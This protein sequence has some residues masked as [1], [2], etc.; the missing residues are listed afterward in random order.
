MLSHVRELSQSCDHTVGRPDYISRQAITASDP[1]RTRANYSSEAVLCKEKCANTYSRFRYA[2]TTAA[3]WRLSGERR[4]KISA[5]AT[6]TPVQLMATS[7]ASKSRGDAHRHQNSLWHLYRNVG[8][9]ILYPGRSFSPFVVLHCRVAR[10]LGVE[11]KQSHLLGR[12]E[13]I[14]C[15]LQRN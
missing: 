13:L 12:I 2:L 4:T 10:V 6:L 1:I 3:L 9:Q 14:P 15:S 8:D 11:G 7:G 5:G